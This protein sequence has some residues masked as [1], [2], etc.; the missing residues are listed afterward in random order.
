MSFSVMGMMLCVFYAPLPWLRRPEAWLAALLAQ[1][2][3]IPEVMTRLSQ[4][5]PL[6]LT[7]GVLIAVLFAWSKPDEKSPS[8]LKLALT[9]LGISLSVWIHGAWY[10]WV[11]PLLAFF[12]AQS[13]RPMFWLTG[14]FTVGIIAGAALTRSPV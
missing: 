5:R 9:C 13:W 3:A 10:L 12:L 7:E 6:L 4:A 14:C 1:M 8:W 11:L 2:V